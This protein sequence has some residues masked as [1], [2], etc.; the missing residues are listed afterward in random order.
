MYIDSVSLAY[1]VMTI[2]F[3]QVSLSVLGGS[4]NIPRR[5]I[6]H[7]ATSAAVP[8]FNTQSLHLTEK[9]IIYIDSV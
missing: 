3:L 2:R 5:F 6:L 8:D 9:L 4:I 1:W 7:Y